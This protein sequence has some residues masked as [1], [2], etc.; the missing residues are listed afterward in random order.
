MSE[1]SL[2]KERRQS[3]RMETSIP[4]RYRVLRDGGAEAVGTS[5]VTCDL[6]TG[7]LCFMANEFLSAACRLTLEL[8]IPALAQP[9]T[10]VSEVA[11]IQ[12]ANRERRTMP[13]WQSIYGNNRQGYGADCEVC[14]RPL[15]VQRARHRKQ[16]AGR[17][18]R[19]LQDRFDARVW[20]SAIYP[21]VPNRDERIARI[22]TCLTSQPR[23]NQALRPIKD[24]HSA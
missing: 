20:L 3:P 8:D 1:A 17:P 14:E 15:T 23:Q 24:R 22:T 13:G 11:W 9:V 10:A 7:G 4:V 18:H 2:S 6:S 12:K 16:E 5:S 21:S 19:Y